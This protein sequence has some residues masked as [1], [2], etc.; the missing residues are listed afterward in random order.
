MADLTVALS[1]CLLSQDGALRRESPRPPELRNASYAAQFDWHTLFYDVF[2]ADDHIVFMGPPLFNLA[3]PLRQSA[4]FRTAFRGFWKQA[5]LVERNRISEIWLRSKADHVQI[6]GPIGQ[7]NVTVQ[8][9]QAAMFAGRRVI[10]TL[11]KDNEIRWIKDWIR[12][13]R[14]VHG[15][16]AVLFY[17]N[18][19]TKYD[20]AGLRGEL[21]AAFPDMVIEVVAWPFLYG[22]QGGMAGAVDGQ[23][24][25]WDSDY[26]QSGSLQHARFRFLRQARSVL[27]VDIDELVL[28]DQGRSIFTATEQSRAGFTKFPGRWITG[29]ADRPIP[30][31][32]ASLGDFVLFDSQEQ[33]VCPPKWCVV[34]HP[35]QRWAQHWSVHNIFG[36]RANRH[37][38]DEFTYR[39]M[40]AIS[41][42][43]K[44]DRREDQVVDPHQFVADE[45]LRQ[46]FE[47]IGLR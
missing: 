33:V 30:A 37:L 19:S 45:P 8:P 16:D 6:D 9:D 42:N 10:H 38:S 23:E 25:P 21:R 15:A 5:R 46:A 2:R 44:A 40:R 32:G 17:D 22:P 26:C 35:R 31:E 34:P 13:Y 36:A 12:F 47:T 14:D 24:A 39:H 43:W 1:R 4:P 28:S 7:W 41:N 18:N 11:S 3:E 20:A 27:N 29:M